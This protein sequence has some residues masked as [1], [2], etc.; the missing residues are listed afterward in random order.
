MSPPPSLRTAWAT[1][2][3][4]FLLLFL[5]LGL[6]TSAQA[7][8]TLVSDTAEWRVYDEG[9]TL[10]S[11]WKDNSYD[12][13]WW[14]DAVG[15]IGW[16][17]GDE[18]TLVNQPAI[19][20]G[21]PTSG[22]TLYLR[23]KFYLKRTGG[24]SPNFTYAGLNGAAI[25]NLYVA[26]K[27]D[28]GFVA[29]INGV[30]VGRSNMPAG[31]VTF[32]TSATSNMEAGTETMSTL[33]LTNWKAACVDGENTL[34][35]EVHQHTPGAN[36]ANAADASVRLRMLGNGATDVITRDPYVNDLA[37]TSVVIRWR[38]TGASWGRVWYAPTPSALF[39]TSSPAPSAATASSSSTEHLVYLSGLTPDTTYSYAVGHFSTSTGTTASSTYA[40]HHLTFRTPPSSSTAAPHFMI[41][42]NAGGANQAIRS[43]LDHYRFMHTS[44][45]LHGVLLTGDS[46]WTSGTDAQVTSNF[47]RTF[48]YPMSHVPAYASAGDRDLATNALSPALFN[49]LTLPPNF[50]KRYYSF[51]RGCVHV[52]C[53]DSAT[54]DAGTRSAMLTWLE[55]D[56]DAVATTGKWIVAYFH[57]SPYTKGDQTSESTTTGPQNIW[58][59]QNVLDILEDHSVDLVITGD[60]HTYERSPL[61]V[62]ARGTP[63]TTVVDANFMDNSHGRDMGNDAGYGSY[64]KPVTKA[65]GQ[66]TVYVNVG[67]SSGAVGTY[68]IPG[69]APL[70]HPVMLP[71]NGSTRGLL[72]IG[73][74]TVDASPTL[75]QFRF[76]ETGGF[77]VDQFN[78]H[79]SA[80][81]LTATEYQGGAR[82]IFSDPPTGSSAKYQIQRSTD[83]TTWS[84]LT[85]I[86]ANSAQYVDNADFDANSR[87]YYRYRFVTESGGT[88]ISRNNLWSNIE[89]V[90]RRGEPT[91]TNVYASNTT[92]T[93]SWNATE[94]A[95]A[96]S[97][98]IQRSA[99]G[100]SFSDIATVSVS[101]GTY[102]DTPGDS[103][104]YYTYRIKAVWASWD[105]DFSSS[106]NAERATTTFTPIPYE[107]RILLSSNN[108][109]LERSYEGGAWTPVTIYGA[110]DMDIELTGTYEY[111]GTYAPGGKLRRLN[112]TSTPVEVI[113]L[114]PSP[115]ATRVWTAPYSSNVSRIVLSMPGG[116]GGYGV[117]MV[118]ARV[119][120]TSAPFTYTSLGGQAY[121]PFPYDVTYDVDVRLGY[122]GW[123]GPI[124]T[125]TVSGS[126]LPPGILTGTA[127]DT[128]HLQVTA[129]G[130]LTIHSVALNGT[131][132][133]TD[134]TDGIATPISLPI[135]LWPSSS[136][137]NVIHYATIFLTNNTLG[138]SYTEN[139]PIANI[140]DAAPSV[141]N[142][143]ASSTD[144]TNH[145]TW[146][147]GD[148]PGVTGF[149]IVRTNDA[150]QVGTISYTGPGSYYIDD[151]SGLG[152]DTL[153]TYQI[154]AYGPGGDAYPIEAQTTTGSPP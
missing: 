49:S 98:V 13:S 25:T 8:H 106:W 60:S 14:K 55:D 93:L 83:G 19:N 114:K 62:G 132:V 82:L 99:D 48:Q 127:L 68:G 154:I 28:D 42:G 144:L 72:D 100:G 117:S 131:V 95:G 12:D 129:T 56:L 47:F 84:H 90:D 23:T 115:V 85:Y 80:I 140:P 111:R 37:P 6:G 44:T 92:V 96:S 136:F 17:D 103:A 71:L 40:S 16:G 105:S 50:L 64:I 76:W 2:A 74:A 102:V 70:D 112:A 77:P 142:P 5:S 145:I 152:Y 36:P 97:I 108:H 141:T 9:G 11:D 53:L 20:F 147:Y 57:D 78:I 58:M 120:A 101:P 133:A 3:S 69:S 119:N 125:F 7:Q 134:W 109:T 79:R 54:T 10:S 123:T 4:A 31:A 30:E 46:A 94:L 73:F 87:Y 113:A 43:T 89:Y 143:G 65:A 148:Y 122:T 41:L 33:T 24:T 126:T 107:G 139:I 118:A 91:L 116:S 81:T 88:I 86:A 150:T 15:E 59:R 27:R 21:A 39:P 153:Y 135:D 35:I 45:Q 29:Y 137:A 130:S 51:D 128:G 121:G 18:D 32:G 146:D 151:T 149:R 1:T 138:V 61:M 66:G 34:C 22:Y 104:E 67:T 26:G 124:Q 38:T 63:T 75:L 52:V 110:Y